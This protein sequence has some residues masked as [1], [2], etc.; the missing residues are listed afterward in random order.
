MVLVYKCIACVSFVVFGFVVVAFFCRLFI[1][2]LI[3][4]YLL[5][6]VFALVS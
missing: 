1:Y 3:C 4:C 6:W 2:R 5:A